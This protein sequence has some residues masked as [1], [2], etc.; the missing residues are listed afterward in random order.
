MAELTKEF[1]PLYEQLKALYKQLDTDMKIEFDRHVS[2]GDLIIDRW[3]R[4]KMYGF[5][6]GTSCYDNVL[7]IGEVKVG[8]NCWIGPNVILDGSGGLVIGDNC[9]ISAGV[10]IYTHD[11]VN[12]ATSMGKSEIDRKATKLGHGV[13]VGPQS[14]VSM[15][16]TI[17]DQCVIGAMSLVKK[18]VA[19]RQKAYGSPAKIV[20]SQK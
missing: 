5:G 11:S 17:G 6:E 20:R 1:N 19:P 14:V 2:A 13:Y 9:S 8:K 3:E 12:W 15:G 4:A 10:Q 7:V 18:D 16:V